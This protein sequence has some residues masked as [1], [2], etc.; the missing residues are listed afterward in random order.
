MDDDILD[1]LEEFDDEDLVDDEDFSS[2][3]SSELELYDA[4]MVDLTEEGELTEERALEVTQAIR[5]AA[6]ATFVLLAY[7]HKNRAHR[8]L[9]YET[10]AEYVKEE[11]DMSAQRSYQLLD[12]SK[13]VHELED[14][15]PEGTEVK[16]T[17]AQARDIK[18]ELPYVTEQVRAA[19]EGKSPKEASDEVGKIV[20][21]VRDDQRP[22]VAEK[23][24]DAAAEAARQAE[25]EEQAD[26]LLKNDPDLLS[27][28]SPDSLTDNADGDFVE[29]M[30][31]G[32]S[33]GDISP[34]DSMN[35]YNFFNVLSGV[36]SLPEP[37]DFIRTIP[38]ARGKEINEQLIEAVS[39][40][41]RFQTLWELEESDDDEQDV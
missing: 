5:S 39:W 30:V 21:K 35:L 37:D 40:M 27:A 23:P 11:F 18:R 41:N 2:D 34:E 19:T 31:D 20:D 10:W 22:E 33:N 17:E 25:L 1:T 13:V 32:E 9:G 14:V 24:G 26:E 4:P 8:V 3:T 7:A 12:L 15:S 28:D 6:T 38:R 29:V 36:T 16:L